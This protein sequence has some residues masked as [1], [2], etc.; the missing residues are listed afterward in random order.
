LK[1]VNPAAAAQISAH[2]PAGT[3]ATTTAPGTPTLSALPSGVLTA[4]SKAHSALRTAQRYLLI[5]AIIGIGASLLISPRRGAILVR[6]GWWAL[7]ASL[8]QLVVWLGLPKL[9]G[10]FHNPWTQV[11]A[12]ALRADGD[13]LLTVFVVLAA[14]GAAFV[15]LG[16][17]SRLVVGLARSM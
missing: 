15:L 6:V 3:T 10:H 7:G 9:L 2:H 16:L 11:A 14:G 4:T 5:I 8:I 12:A 17:A 13:G 1:K